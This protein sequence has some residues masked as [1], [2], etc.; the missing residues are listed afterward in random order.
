MQIILDGVGNESLG[1]VLTSKPVIPTAQRSVV[2]TMV[3]GS[4][5]GSLT[6]F[7]GWQDV[8]VTCEFTIV[9][10]L[11]SGLSGIQGY[12]DILRRLN[13]W[14]FDSQKLVFSD[15]F[16]FYRLVKNVVVED[17]TPQE[18]EVVGS[19]SVTFTLDP[20]WYKDSEPVVL[21]GTQSA[22][23]NPGTQ[24]AEPLLTV[25]GS[26]TIKF[27]VNGTE[28]TLLKVVDYLTIDSWEKTVIH[29]SDTGI[30]D[31]QL[32]GAYPVLPPGDNEI[33]LGTA[34]KIVVDGR[35]PWR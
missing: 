3:P 14:A 25:Y 6:Q 11:F 19:V 18:I 2:S 12:N 31:E 17:A 24:P 5:H 15:D 13:G 21:T 35:W 4:T 7:Q 20:F 32:D 33:K 29:G 22:V 34:S 16:G 9:Q 8:E 28:L 10:T 1:I 26:G 27:T 23:Y 30:Y